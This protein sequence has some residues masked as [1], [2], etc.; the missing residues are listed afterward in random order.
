MLITMQ[1]TR[2]CTKKKENG[3]NDGNLTLLLFLPFIQPDIYND[4]LHLT[5]EKNEYTQRRT[6]TAD[7][8]HSFK[9][10]WIFHRA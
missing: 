10:R 4:A 1:L 9:N 6:A 5:S 7:K 2:V 3:R 8:G